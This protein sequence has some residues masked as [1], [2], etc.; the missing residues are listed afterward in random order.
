[1]RAAALLSR[2]AVATTPHEEQAEPQP[3]RPGGRGAARRCKGAAPAAMAAAVFVANT[4]HAMA[5]WARAAIGLRRVR[6]PGDR[7]A[8]PCLVARVARRARH[9]HSA[10]ARAVLARIRLRTG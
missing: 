9:R 8:G 2:G 4:V 10:R 1:M 5:A 7:I 3:R 6:A